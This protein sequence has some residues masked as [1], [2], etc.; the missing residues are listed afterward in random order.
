METSIREGRAEAKEG[1]A[2]VRSLRDTMTTWRGWIA[3]AMATGGVAGGVVVFIIE[4][5]VLKHP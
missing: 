1:R 4:K 2:E 3:G 5:F